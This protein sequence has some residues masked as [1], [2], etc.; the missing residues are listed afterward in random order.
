MNLGNI[1]L[2]ILII[3]IYLIIV[4]SSDGKSKK[5][6]K[7]ASEST[8]NIE[9]CANVAS[10]YRDGTLRVSSAELNSAKFKNKITIDKRGCN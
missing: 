1:L 10:L 8:P 9:A 3:S 4:D 2:L 7:F 5:A 6:E